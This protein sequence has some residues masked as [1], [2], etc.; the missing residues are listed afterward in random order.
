LADLRRGVDK[1]AWVLIDSHP[2]SHVII[3]FS[4]TNQLT[5]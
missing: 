5:N 3:E 2:N 4:P 1:D